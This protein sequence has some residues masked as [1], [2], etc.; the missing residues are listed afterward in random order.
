MH[1]YY[2]VKPDSL[3]ISL[4]TCHMLRASTKIVDFIPWDC[5]EEW[6][7]ADSIP[8]KEMGFTEYKLNCLNQ[9]LS[10]KPLVSCYAFRFYTTAFKTRRPEVLKRQH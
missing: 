3:E 1:K 6:R 5:R 7:S 8:N 2:C 9:A 10:V 4:L